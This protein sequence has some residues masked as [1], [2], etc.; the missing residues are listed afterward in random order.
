MILFQDDWDK[1]PN[2]IID[3]TTTNVS[4]LKMYSILQK[5][6][7]KNNKFFLALLDSELKNIDPHNLKDNSKELRMRIIAEAYRNPFFYFR[8]IVRIPVTGGD[9]QFLLHRANLAMY[10]CYLNNIDIFVC[11]PRQHG[12]TAAVVAM[13][14]YLQYIKA[15]NFAFSLTTRRDDLRSNTVN[16]FKEIRDKLPSWMIYKNVKDKENIFEISY[17]ALK[18]S[19]RSNVPPMDETSADGFGRG[20]TEASRHLDEFNYLRY[21][22]IF[23][24]VMM[25][26]TIAAR[27]FAKKHNLPYSDIYTS[28]AGRLD[29]KPGAFGYKI[30]SNGMQFFDKL[31]DLKN[32][33]ELNEILLKNSNNKIIYILYSFLQLG[34][35]MEWFKEQCLLTQDEDIIDR[36]LKCI[37]RLGS[38]DSLISPTILKKI[39]EYEIE[40]L[41]TEIHDNYTTK[42]Y[43]SEEEANSPS[44]LRKSMIMGIDMSENIG[45]DFTVKVMID[46][47]TLKVIS[48]TRNNYTDLLSIAMD[49]IEQMLKMP[50]LIII[51]ERNSVGAAVIDII[52]VH[53]AKH[54]VNA[55]H[56][57]FNQ[58]IQNKDDKKFQNI[59]INL[60]SFTYGEVR[61]YF[62]FRTMGSGNEMSKANT[63]KLLF[64]KVLM[65]CLNL[66]YN[67]IYD[68]TLIRELG[69]LSL[70]KSGRVDH[71]IGEHDD[72]V[73]SYLLA[74]YFIFFGKNLDRYGIDS[75]AINIQS[76]DTPPQDA[77]IMSQ[78]HRQYIVNRI[79]ELEQSKIRIPSLLIQKQLDREINNLKLIIKD[80][81]IV[82]NLIGVDQ[83]KDHKL[84][85][86]YDNNIVD[87]KKVDDLTRIFV[88]SVKTNL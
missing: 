1:Y 35:D 68:A 7:I 78:E 65:K 33:N 71:P 44:F 41:Y 84:E 34:K 37:W 27:E 2:A 19:Y 40:P 66:C 85:G 31:Y 49:I 29:S 69:L 82:H 55:F 50:K 53:L 23:F 79:E 32:K 21:N 62:G 54:G 8:Q 18:N 64:S 52:L 12:K 30:I 14:V 57:I 56:R 42:W 46:P 70:T 38:D 20:F 61:K 17:D 4:F 3:T 47:Y 88:R 86:S 58:V 9:S 73:I 22:H 25:G 80:V 60:E 6:G 39:K 76:D 83:L 77:N 63:R 87:R 16:L 45:N 75:S 13:N 10:W 51:P 43:I 36:D 24:P 74:N 48:I 72:S 5:L 11:I 26:A 67:K 15:K 59:P 28:T 81:P